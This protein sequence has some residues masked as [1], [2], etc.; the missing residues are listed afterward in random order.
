MNRCYW[1]MQ[2][3][4]IKKAVFF[5]LGS[6]G[7]RHLRNLKILHPNVN[8]YYFKET[9]K[10]F[11]INDNL[12]KINKNILKKYKLTLVKNLKDLKLINP[13]IA[14]ICNPSSRH[15][16]FGVYC[17]KIGCDLFIEK[18]I[19]NSLLSIEK[20]LKLIIKNKLIV[21]V[22]YQFL[23]HPLT[24][25][26]KEIINH[27]AF[28]K[29]LR[30]E[31]IMNEDVKKYRKYGNFHDLLITKKK[32]GGGILLE[33][34]H[35]LSVLAWLFNEKLEVIFSNVYNHKGLGF[36]SGAEDA[37]SA[38]LINTSKGKKSFFNVHLSSFA[39]KKERQ[40]TFFYQ[41]GKIH[42]DYIKNV[43]LIETN[44]NKKFF[45]TKLNRNQL[46]ISELKD[47]LNRVKNRNFSNP[48]LFNSIFTL[49]TVIKA[50]K[51]SSYV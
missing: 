11:Y 35:D 27:S 19:S 26:L 39:N 7:Q 15:M 9:N 13:D 10:N 42:L 18:P 48:T 38:F 16:F 8:V 49:K 24:K 6:A 25:K 45:K 51:I 23:Y 37:A 14:F 33:Q 41:K 2:K 4:K 46:F 17:A 28:G 20:F 1:L 31:V 21:N 12:E 3:S 5:G 43:L 50:K 32:K 47:F 40:M 29:L 30:G 34:S 44:K 36:E 22:G